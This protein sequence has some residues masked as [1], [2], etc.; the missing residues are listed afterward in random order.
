MSEFMTVSTSSP[1]EGTVGY[2]RAVRAG[3]HVF[4]AGTMAANTQ[5][6]IQSPGNPYEQT[7]YAFRKAEM[8]MQEAGAKL[9]N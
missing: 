3:T 4:V 5:G 6:E 8:A 7:I 9:E 1:W 2:S